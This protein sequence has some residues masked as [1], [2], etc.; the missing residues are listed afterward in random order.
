M[1]KKV[2]RERKIWSCPTFK[3]APS[4]KDEEGQEEEGGEVVQ[5]SDHHTFG[6]WEGFFGGGCTCA[7]IHCEVEAGAAGG[8]WE[9]VVEVGESQGAGDDV[10]R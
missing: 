10:R 9:G 8:N 3:E 7:F 6:A 5:G 4:T 1:D 2:K